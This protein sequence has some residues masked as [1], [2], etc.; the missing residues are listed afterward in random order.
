MVA[1]SGIMPTTF[2][3]MFGYSQLEVGTRV[4]AGFGDRKVELVLALD[5]TGSMNDTGPAGGRGRSTSS[6][7]PRAISLLG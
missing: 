3:R 7:R 6:R 4:E 5:N 2:M 1:A